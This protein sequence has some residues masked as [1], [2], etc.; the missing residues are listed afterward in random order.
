M[1]QYIRKIPLIEEW[2]SSPK[3]AVEGIFGEGIFGSQE[4]LFK[5]KKHILPF[6]VLFC[7][8]KSEKLRASFIS[9]NLVAGANWPRGQKRTVELSLRPRKGLSLRLNYAELVPEYFHLLPVF[10]QFCE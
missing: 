2:E 3:T 4:S 8:K 9:S 7:E 10:D 5:Y 6:L 1:E